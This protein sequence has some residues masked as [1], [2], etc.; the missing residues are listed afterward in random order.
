M[1]FKLFTE[2]RSTF[3]EALQL[4]EREDAILARISSQ[5]EFDFV[6]QLVEPI[7]FQSFF[8]GMRA[9][10]NSDDLTPNRFEFVD[11][12]EDKSFFINRAN[13]H[14]IRMSQI[15]EIP[16]ANSVLTV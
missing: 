16:R 7:A 2:P 4:C 5:E 14:G 12:F 11:D 1:E 9:P 3:D 10:E 15:F 13:F 8:L 6:L